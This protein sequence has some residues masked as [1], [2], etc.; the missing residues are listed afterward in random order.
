MHRLAFFVAL[1]ALCILTGCKSAEEKCELARTSAEQAWRAYIAS[2]E[3]AQADALATQADAKSKLAGPI[4][5]RLS[6]AAA[7]AASQ[8]YDRSTDAWQRAYQAN[9]SAACANDPECTQLKDANAEA[10]DRAGD[11][12]RKLPQARSALNALRADAQ[13]AQRSAAEITPEQG[14]TPLQNAKLGS[15]AVLTA[16]KDLPASSH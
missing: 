12:A 9:Q 14:N 13:S 15:A 8:R 6:E 5:A 2:M 3:S 10:I 1:C 4:E 11:L 7:R 16:C